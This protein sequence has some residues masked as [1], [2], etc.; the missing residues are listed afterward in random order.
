ML[1]LLLQHL[2]LPTVAEPDGVPFGQVL[3]KSVAIPAF[4]GLYKAD[5]LMN[6][7]IFVVFVDSAGCKG[8]AAA[9]LLAIHTICKL[10]SRCEPV[11]RNELTTK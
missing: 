1:K 8:G 9:A 5:V 3:Q 7:I 11:P 2:I 10:I 6:D 4:N